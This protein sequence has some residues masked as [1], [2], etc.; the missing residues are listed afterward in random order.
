M[1]D[2]KEDAARAAWLYFARSY[3]QK[4]VANQLGITRQ[5]GFRTRR[6]WPLTG[7]RRR[8]P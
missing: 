6:E 2:Q 3:T 8:D 1:I 5:K 7:L 4:Q